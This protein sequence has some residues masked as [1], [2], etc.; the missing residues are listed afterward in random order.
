[1]AVP[2]CCGLEA[3]FNDAVSFR[4]VEA[5]IAGL[6]ARRVVPSPGLTLSS[7]AGWV[8]LLQ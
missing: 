3:V 7:K 6:M 8:R 1:M 5:A 4:P 2:S